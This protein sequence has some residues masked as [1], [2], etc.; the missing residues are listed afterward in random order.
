MVS[1]MNVKLLDTAH[2]ENSRPVLVQGAAARLC[3]AAVSAKHGER[4]KLIVA[5]IKDNLLQSTDILLRPDVRL[6]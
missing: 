5:R 3:T 1:L 4:V 6:K 2:P